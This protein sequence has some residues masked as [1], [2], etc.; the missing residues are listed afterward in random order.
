MGW[1]IGIMIIGLVGPGVE[2]ITN[3]SPRQNVWVT[4][5]NQT[6]NSAF[7][8]SMATP[9]DPFRTCLIGFPFLR[10]EDFEGYVSQ[11]NL[12]N[13]LLLE[14]EQVNVTCNLL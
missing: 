7:C 11:V 9:S 2:G 10:L 14:S 6:G 5:A 1:I 8:L 12:T 4:W 13:S 3:I